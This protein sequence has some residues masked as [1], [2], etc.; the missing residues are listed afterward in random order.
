VALAGAINVLDVTDI[1]LG[2]VFASLATWLG[3]AVR[4][5]L[6]SRVLA[7][8]WSAPRVRSSA[9]GGRAAV[10]GAAEAALDAIRHHPARF[11]I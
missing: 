2:G 10:R 5:E 4:S 7:S 11:I 1:A 3:P 9:L 6:D 8:R